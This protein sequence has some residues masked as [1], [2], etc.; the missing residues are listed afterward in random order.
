MDGVVRVVPPAEIDYATAGDL[1]KQISQA[2]ASGAATVAIDFEAVTFCDSSGLRVLVQA[3]KLARASGHGFV[4]VNP[5]R[6]L[7]RLAD[8]LQASEL[9]DLPRP[10]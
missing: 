6:S 2:I 3:A 9:L 8:I 4:V 10:L 5:T 7:L 1:A